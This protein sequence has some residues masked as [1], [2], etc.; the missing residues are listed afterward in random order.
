MR[1]VHRS[2]VVAGSLALATFHSSAAGD[3]ASRTN[4]IDNAH[5]WLSISAFAEIQSAYLLPLPLFPAWI[6]LCHGTASILQTLQ[7][8]L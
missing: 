5:E 7:Q 2:L 3:A 1:S 6:F 8:S 4:F